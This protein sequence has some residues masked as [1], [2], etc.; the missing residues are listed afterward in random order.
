MKQR[1]PGSPTM[2]F[3]TFLRSACRR[4]DA[5][6]D[7]ASALLVEIGNDRSRG[8]C[9]RASDLCAREAESGSTYQGFKMLWELW[10]EEQAREYER[11]G[12]LRQSNA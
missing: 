3:A 1:Q 6:G 8:A 11:T 9:Q 12:E 5:A 10:I 7:A 2:D 4:H